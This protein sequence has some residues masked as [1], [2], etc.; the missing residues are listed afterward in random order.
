MR[1]SS[2]N[3]SAVLAIVAGLISLWMALWP[4][5]APQ[6]LLGDLTALWTAGLLLVALGCIAAP[7][8]VRISTVA[9]KVILASA[10]VAL[11]GSGVFFWLAT[12]AGVAAIF[13][14]VPGILAAVAAFLIGPAERPEVER[15]KRAAAR[16]PQRE[17]RERPRRVA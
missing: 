3:T 10:A 7:F 11:F 17:Y 8:L 12:G 5:P 1:I 2:N 14:F 16:Y 9:A 13:D 15:A 6:G 4:T